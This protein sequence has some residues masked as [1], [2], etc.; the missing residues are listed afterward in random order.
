MRPRVGVVGFGFVGRAIVHGFKQYVDFEIND[1][2]LEDSVPLEKLAK[3]C[4]IVF[5][6]VP[7]PMKKKTGQIDTSI[8]DDVVDQLHTHQQGAKQ[9]PIIVIKSTV[10]P[11]TLRGYVEKYPGIR[12]VMNPEFL[13]EKSAN[14][15]FINQTRVV[16]GGKYEDVEP[17]GI[18]YKRFG[19]SHVPQW[20]MPLEAAAF[21]KYMCNT[22]LATKLS[23]MN[24]WYQLAEKA[25][26]G[27][28]WDS[29]INAFLGDGRIG[30]SHVRVPGPDGQ[31]GWGG[32][33][34]PKDLNAIVN[35]ADDQL[36]MDMLTLKAAW[37]SNQ[38]VRQDRD[39]EFIEGA[40]SDE[41]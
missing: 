33:C 26:L 9:V 7:T 27:Y 16:L 23:F 14:L 39:W 8:M 29:M 2:K 5:V 30:N 41:D 18:F 20:H 21:V 38:R 28:C 22:F 25:S 34:F 4:A 19:Y 36:G 12:L 40:T 10:T 37:E 24:E 17:L 32:K 1:P 35:Y 15:D 13:T 11:H 6:G 31:T 3:E